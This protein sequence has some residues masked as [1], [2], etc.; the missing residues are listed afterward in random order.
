MLNSN[1]ANYSADLNFTGT[2]FFFFLFFKF[3]PR[4]L[5]LPCPLLFDSDSSQLSS[6]EEYTGS[7]IHLS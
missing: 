7:L 2:V 5:T 4:N 6:S 3:S 1:T